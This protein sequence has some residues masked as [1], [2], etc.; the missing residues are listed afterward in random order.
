MDWV[1]LLYLSCSGALISCYGSSSFDGDIPEILPIKPVRSGTVEVSSSLPF[2]GRAGANIA[3]EHLT[4]VRILD[5]VYL[6]Q[7]GSQA[8]NRSVDNSASP[9]HV[10]YTQDELAKVS[11]SSKPTQEFTGGG[12]A[13]RHPQWI[14]VC[15]TYAY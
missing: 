14:R 8:L 3:P 4:T 11:K 9:A 2:E 7:S 5:P 6:A 10:T 1:W 15:R 12:E 13:L